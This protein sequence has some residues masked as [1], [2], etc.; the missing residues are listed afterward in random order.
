M[1]GST[2]D[3]S[4]SRQDLVVKEKLADLGFAGVESDK[5]V[6]AKWTR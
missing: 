6:I 3:I 4:V 5:V 2:R 1:A